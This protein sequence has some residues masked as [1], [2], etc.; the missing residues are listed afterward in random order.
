MMF[1]ALASTWLGP[2]GGF[3]IWVGDRH[4]S[5]IVEELRRG[6]DACDQQ[7]ISRAGTGDIA[8]MTLCVIDLL[9]IGIVVDS[10][11]TLL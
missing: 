6:L 3:R 11:N 2:R 5:E 7:V 9:Q 4:H 8:Q 1:P 10:R